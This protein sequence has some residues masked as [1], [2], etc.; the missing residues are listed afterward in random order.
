MEVAEDLVDDDTLNLCAS[1]VQSV[2]RRFLDRV[3]IIQKVNSRFEKILD[4]KRGLYYYYDN[5]SDLSSWSKPRLLREGDMTNIAPTYSKDLAAEIITCQYLKLYSLRRVQRKY[6]E[7]VESVK[8]DGIKGRRYRKVGEESTFE[9]LPKFME[10]T[11]KHGYP[12]D[13]DEDDDEDDDEESVEDGVDEE[14]YDSG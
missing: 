1:K 8:V 7:G 3:R 2:I 14:E 10:G 11:L 13:E 12:G 6:A 4:P 5:V 9:N